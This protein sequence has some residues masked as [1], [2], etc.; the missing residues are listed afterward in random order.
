MGLPQGPVRQPLI[1]LS[2]ERTEALRADLDGLGLLDS[3]S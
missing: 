2:E 1:A 3:V